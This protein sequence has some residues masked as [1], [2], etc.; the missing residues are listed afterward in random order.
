METIL[1]KHGRLAL[2]IKNRTLNAGRYSFQRESERKIH[3]DIISKLKITIKDKCLDVGCNVGA[4]LIPLSKKVKHITGIDQVN[5]INI[6]RNNLKAKNVSLI[7][8]SFLDHD[9][10]KS[11]YDKIIIYSVL[12]VFKNK[13]EAY[14][15]IN[16]ALK[17]LNPGGK[18]LIGDLPN[19]SLKNKFLNSKSGQIF[20]KEW[21]KNNKKT[22][23]DIEA[24]NMLVKDTNSNLKIN[25]RFIINLLV[26][27]RKKGLSVF[28]LP[29]NKELP[30]GNTR[31]DIVIESIK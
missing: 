2:K 9:F 22:K 4:N 27:L 29:Q 24:Q 25:D 16:K 11:K 6:L 10:K 3:R 18:I 23:M 12:H 8:G 5:C 28:I 20:S 1:E 7:G 14:F 15:V 30:F 31:E 21:S 19:I 13:K 26:Y 17:L